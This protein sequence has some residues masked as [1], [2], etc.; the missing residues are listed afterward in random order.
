MKEKEVVTILNRIAADFTELAKL[1]QD[2]P[3]TKKKPAKETAAAKDKEETPAAK[4]AAP[5]AE[6]TKEE[7]A[8]D[9]NFDDIRA[10]LAEKAAG[11]CRQQVKELLKEYSL[12][13]LSDIEAH[14][15]LFTEILEKARAM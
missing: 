12:S 2:E 10:L 7:P 5:A 1:M 15:E 3:Q 4:E 11:G 9:I 13:C 6:A 14:P 8:N